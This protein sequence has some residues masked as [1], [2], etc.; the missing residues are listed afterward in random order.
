MQEKEF[1][2]PNEDTLGGLVQI[3]DHTS[4]RRTVQL[5]ENNTS[6]STKSER[7]LCVEIHVSKCFMFVIMW[8]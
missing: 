4:Q 2:N 6:T 7:E 3:L 8:C 1:E 5:A